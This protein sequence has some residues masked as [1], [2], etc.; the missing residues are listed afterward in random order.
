M[1]IVGN[2]NNHWSR[3]VV[4]NSPKE[5]K[6]V[7]V[8]D[9]TATISV[10]KLRN[11]NQ[12]ITGRETILSKV[13]FLEFVF[14]NSKKDLPNSINFYTCFNICPGKCDKIFINNFN[15]SKQKYL[16][17]HEELVDEVWFLGSPLIEKKIITQEA[18]DTVF[19]A[20]KKFA[21]KKSLEIK[22]FPHRVENLN[23]RIDFE[24]VK[25]NIPFEIYYLKSNKRPKYI[26]GYFSTSLYVLNR[27]D[28]KT[29]FV[30]ISINEDWRGKANWVRIDEVYDFFIYNKMEVYNIKT[31]LEL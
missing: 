27:M 3:Y 13:G 17:N 7:V 4:K 28:F 5:I 20:L 10:L 18:S 12:D 8:D 22:Y 15:Y 19:S 31:L 29:K 1:P 2:L 26:L 16:C 23:K 6:P 14:L 25:N 30:P 9:G 11:K 21:K 24:I